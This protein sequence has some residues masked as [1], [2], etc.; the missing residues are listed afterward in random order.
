[1]QTTD[2]VLGTPST[3]GDDEQLTTTRLLRDA[4][5]TF[6]DQQIIHTRGG[7]SPWQTT[8]YAAVWERVRRMAAAL[9]AENYQVE[10]RRENGH[11][12]VIAEEAVW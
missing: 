5:R 6:G 11:L 4:A 3:M 7:G 9:R 2:T 1:M 8:T 10:I 12:E